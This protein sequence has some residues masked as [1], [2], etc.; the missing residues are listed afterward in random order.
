MGFPGDKGEPGRQGDKGD[1]GPM[2]ESGLPGFMG[3][4]GEKGIRGNPGERVSNTSSLFKLNITK[5]NF[6]P[7]LIRDFTL[8][9]Q[10]PL[11][12]MQK[13][14]ILPNNIILPLIGPSSF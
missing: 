13:T 10:K 14:P 5:L 6:Y 8:W 2:G 4:T 1:M 7:S 11:R 12:L 3:S 9:M